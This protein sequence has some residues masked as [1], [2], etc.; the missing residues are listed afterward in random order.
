MATFSNQ[1]KNTSPTY[2][3]VQKHG[4]NQVIADVGSY[5][6]EDVMFLND[7]LTSESRIDEFYEQSWS[8]QNKN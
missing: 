7:K 5:T 3:N 4:E 8:N 2:L 1:N 6:F